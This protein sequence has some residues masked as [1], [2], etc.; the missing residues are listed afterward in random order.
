MS[1]DSVF[2]KIIKREIPATIR[3]E[4]DAF[5]A[6]DDIHPNAPFDIVIAS[7][8]PFAT[9]L[10]IPYEREDI[11][12]GLLKTAKKTAKAVGIGEN[13]RIVMNVGHHMQLIKHVHL[14]LMGGWD[15]KRILKVR[16]KNI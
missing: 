14:H 3:Y 16:E 2:T 12:A 7:K 13:Y 10:D 11:L 9:L 15:Q 6:F 5:I 1:E 4:D 8:E